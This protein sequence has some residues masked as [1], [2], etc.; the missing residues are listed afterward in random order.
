MAYLFDSQKIIE[1]DAR[2]PSYTEKM[3]SWT[4]VPAPKY[5]LSFCYIGILYSSICLIKM[6]V[7]FHILN[8]RTDAF[9]LNVLMI[10]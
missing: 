3:S 8:T 10:V 9:K 7:H 2:D 5:F 4:L 6:Y 1:A